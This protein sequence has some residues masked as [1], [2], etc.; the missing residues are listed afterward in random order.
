MKQLILASA[1]PRRK[2][3]LLQ[4]G[5]P[6]SVEIGNVDETAIAKE[7]SS[8]KETVCRL[9]EAK[10]E[11][12]LEKQIKEDVLV[13]GS[14]TVVAQG[15]RI[16][17]KPKSTEEAFSMLMEL[18]GKKH[19]VYTGFALL[20]QTS[21][22]IRKHVE[23]V[24]TDVYFRPLTET[25]IHAYIATGEPMDKA[26]AYGIQGK[27]AFL[28]DHIAG[29]YNTVVGLPLARLGCAL[30]KMGVEVTDFWKEGR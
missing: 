13:L 21:E 28:V 20:E 1:S 16:F 2:E 30:R 24:E 18:A 15:S 17:H 3:L 6:F 11:N 27:G 25:E 22:G 7:A 9:A 8:P 23:A 29:D 14:D 12:V 5:I 10:A 26:G 4:L 19:T